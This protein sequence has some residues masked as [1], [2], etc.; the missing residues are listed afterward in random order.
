MGLYEFFRNEELSDCTLA[1]DGERFRC[2]RLVLAHRSP[3]CRR[4]LRDSACGVEIAVALPCP[5]GAV[6]GQLLYYCYEGHLPHEIAA[7]DSIPL[8]LL[9]ARLEMGALQARLEGSLVAALQTPR[10]ALTFLALA[11]HRAPGFGDEFPS[12]Q[13]RSVALI[14]QGLESVWDDLYQLNPRQMQAV[15]VAPDCVQ[16]TALISHTITQ[17]LRRRVEMSQTEPSATDAEPLSQSD[18]ASL[19]E[20]VHEIHPNDIM[21]LLGLSIR[22]KDRRMRKKCL[23]AAAQYADDID[24]DPDVGS[25]NPLFGPLEGLTEKHLS[26]CAGHS[27][28]AEDAKGGRHSEA[29]D[30]R[31]SGA[32]PGL[33]VAGRKRPFFR[34]SQVTQDGVDP[35]EPCP[36]DSE[37]METPAAKAARTEAPL[38]SSPAA[39]AAAGPPTGAGN[40]GALPQTPALWQARSDPAGTPTPIPSQVSGFPTDSDRPDSPRAHPPPPPLPSGQSSQALFTLPDGALASRFDEEAASEMPPAEMIRTT[41]GADHDTRG[42]DAPADESPDAVGQAEDDDPCSQ[43]MAA[44]VADIGRAIDSHRDRRESQVVQLL[45]GEVGRLQ[46]RIRAVRSAAAKDR[47]EFRAAFDGKLQAVQATLAGYEARLQGDR[48]HL[49]QRLEAAAAEQHR[50][51]A[52]VHSLREEFEQ[53]LTQLEER[54]QQFFAELKGSVESD[55]ASLDHRVKHA[56]Q[57]QIAKV[58]SKFL[59]DSAPNPQQ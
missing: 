54:E 55:L 49:E 37:T 21:V 33:K 58:L 14:A 9:A 41:T 30:G 48:R 20:H 4:M 42:P 47:V 46:D 59:T 36:A 25:G 32:K 52:E 24:W 22:L 23:L 3:Y 44:M 17:F 6:V 31:L 7:T 15:L 11:N 27:F 45:R 34:A 35:R 50:R 40:V 19:C 53:G 51:T 43:G 57:Q 2:H 13:D 16:D 56:S 29:T 18:F 28:L 12:I 5:V 8:L 26:P 39:T 1:V 10:A 38:A